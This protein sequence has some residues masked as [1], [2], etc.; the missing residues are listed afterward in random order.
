MAAGDTDL[1]GTVDLIVCD[2][3]ASVSRLSGGSDGTLG[4]PVL[5]AS[6]PIGGGITYPRSIAD[7]NR[8]GKPD[9]VVV[10][11]TSQLL[12]LIQNSL[13][14]FDGTAPQSFPASTV[15]DLVTGDWNRDGIV[16]VALA[17]ANGLGVSLGTGSGTLATGSFVMSGRP[18]TAVCTGD[19]N[20]DGTPDLAVRES[21]TNLVVGRGIDV[22]LGTGSGTF[23]LI[24][25]LWVQDPIGSTIAAADV[26]RDGTLD[27]IAQ[28]II[29]PWPSGRVPGEGAEV[30]LGAGNGT[31]TTTDY[32]GK[33]LLG[34]SYPT[35]GPFTVADVDR[36]GAADI[37]TTR[38]ISDVYR[39]TTLLS[40]PP[41]KSNGLRD[42]AFYPTLN[43][44][45]H[46][47]VGDLNRDGKP[48][49]VTGA[50]GTN[51][52]VAVLLGNGNG[53]LGT[54]TTLAQSW[55]V[56][57][58]GLADFNRDGIL[59][60]AACNTGIG[61]PRVS[62]MLGV[63][64]GTFGARNDY[65]INAGLDFEIADMNRDGKMDCVTASQD[66]IQVLLGTGTGTFT[67][68][69]KVAITPCYDLDLADLNRDGY[70][71][72]V[73]ASGTV[74]V[75]Y[76][77]AN[78]TFGAPVTLSAPLTNCQTL[79]VAD[80]N[81]DGF[82]DI[83]ANN[84]TVYYVIWGAAASPFSS[85]ATSTLAFTAFDM[86][87]GEAEANGVP[88]VYAS[89]N[90]E[91]VEVLSVS[92]A[93][94]LASI[95]SYAVSNTPEGLALGDFDRDGL[96]DVVSAG[97]GGSFV[98]VNLHGIAGFITGVTAAAPP[99]TRA[100]LR[101]NYPNPFNPR[102][103]IRYALP[104]TERAHLAIFDVQG[105]LVA[106][107][108]DG[109]QAAGEHTIEWDGRNRQGVSVG[110]GIYLYRLSTESGESQARRMVV[111]K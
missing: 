93:G 11:S 43:N 27:L 71:D 18:Y 101:Q 105:R 59:D 47:A 4:S 72:I 111:V 50:F 90:V 32:L 48:D 9:L 61:A 96:V 28:A 29:Y 67:A 74:K 22:F 110:S 39:I 37:V 95:G 35:D 5:V 8:D 79:C 102:T 64:D 45:G 12:T 23:N 17:T 49:V 82:L 44:P 83:V 54:S 20:K 34:V 70:L 10:S 77:A 6:P 13:G 87:M 91:Q 19:F 40:N 25:T 46:V 1:N 84:F 108:K 16:D 73:C 94:V 30:H 3:V 31:F 52:G 99:V 15:N 107:L 60:I 51:P 62:T 65:Y 80:F 57:Q 56:N 88:Y 78:G 14:G 97:S 89:R 76:Q 33:Y 24:Q 42:A 53:T 75:F 98:A 7:L 81:R 69:T 38:L 2:G 58:V 109:V 104:R 66:S 85:Y 55:T 86:K 21:A 41:A 100:H 106:T 103:T 26:N 92:Q 36:D 68:G 63:G